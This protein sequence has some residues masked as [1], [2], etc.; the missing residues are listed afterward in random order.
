MSIKYGARRSSIE[1]ATKKK[2][3]EKE[4]EKKKNHVIVITTKDTKTYFYNK[5]ISKTKKESIWCVDVTVLILYFNNIIIY[6]IIF[7]KIL[8]C[9]FHHILVT[10]WYISFKI[11]YN[12][13]F[14]IIN[15]LITQ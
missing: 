12:N 5:I 6:I 15:V 4:E 9:L 13:T 1:L 3:N 10:V 2:K 7:E 14:S 8:N 11:K